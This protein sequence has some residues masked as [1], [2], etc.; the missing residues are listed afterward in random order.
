M[1]AFPNCKINLGLQVRRKRADGF[2]DL[3]TVFYPVAAQDA[4]E[5]LQT[6]G[7]GTIQF[8]ASGRT[9]TRIPEQNICFKAY[10][11]LRERFPGL[12]SVRVHLHKVLPSG[13]G[14]G[15]GSADGAYC[16]LLLNQKL[17]LGLSTGELA[18]LALRLGSDCPFFIYN[19]PAFAQGRGELLEPV[20]LS[21]AGYQLLL[22]HPGVHVSTAQAFRLVRPNDDRPSLRTLLHQP[23]TAWQETLHNDF[24]ASVFPQFPEIAALKEQIRAR[25]AVYAAMSGSGSSVFGIFHPGAQPQ[26]TGFPAHYFVRSVTLG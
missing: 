17:H 3:E 5:V 2:H 13:A 25:G 20:A 14:L 1:L 10:Q 15:G 8:S 19:T 21:L 11:L 22:V 9:V 6:E 12:P 23:V 24:E 16:L 18:G 26:T 4:L 7:E